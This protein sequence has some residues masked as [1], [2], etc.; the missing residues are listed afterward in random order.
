MEYTKISSVTGSLLFLLSL[1]LYPAFSHS[2]AYYVDETTGNDSNNEGTRASPWETIGHAVNVASDNDTIYIY[3]GDYVESIDLKPVPKRGLLLIGLGEDDNLPVIQS[4]APDIHTV[5]VYEFSGT[6]QGLAVT[7]ATDANGININETSSTARIINCQI[8]GNRYGIHITGTSSPLIRNNRI[9]A[10]R[11]CGI[12]NMLNSSA[13]ID[14]NQMYENGNF[15]GALAGICVRDQSSPVIQ[16]NIIRDNHPSGIN[17]RDTAS[18]IIVNNT[19]LNHNEQ[20]T[21]GTAVK[22]NQERLSSPW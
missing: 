5:D 16:N 7:G 11:I 10:N 6:L 2:T 18:P 17:V 19:L 21:T 20:D 1:I 9:S 13:K 3:P 22:V 14:G 8:Y 12:G 4:M 15:P